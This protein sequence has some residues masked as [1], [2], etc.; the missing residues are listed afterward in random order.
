VKKL[1]S[2]GLNSKFAVSGLVISFFSILVFTPEI[3]STGADVISRNITFF[4]TNSR[5]MLPV[6]TA[7][8][9]CVYQAEPLSGNLS[10]TS[11]S[12]QN[13]IPLVSASPGFYVKNI[14]PAK[15]I[16]FPDNIP[17]KSFRQVCLL[18]DLPPPSL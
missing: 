9:E 16:F 14:Y 18:L 15:Y 2:R 13:V 4:A 8:V 3:N 11:T 6:F 17:R 5:T 10:K 12:S 7:S 1:R